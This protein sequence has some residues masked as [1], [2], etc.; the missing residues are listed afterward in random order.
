MQCEYEPGGS[1]TRRL[2]AAQR[3]GVYP[4][5]V[6]TDGRRSAAVATL[7][8]TPGIQPGDPLAWCEARLEIP[9]V[10]CIVLEAAGAATA[11]GGAWM[12]RFPRP[13]IFAFADAVPAGLAAL[14][15]GADIRVCGPRSAIAFPADP[16]PWL[17]IRGERLLVEG[18][19][20]PWGQVVDAEALLGLGLA[21]RI[22]AN[23]TTEA[24]RLAGVIAARGPIATELGKEAVWRGI[25]MPLEQALRLET[26]LTLLLQTTKDRAEGVRAFLEKRTPR[27]TGE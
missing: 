20:P 24:H 14:A 9:A 13:V 8:L 15:L 6:P 11:D 3:F 17:R 25:E 4:W 10:R 19:R 12:V 26:D 1:K 16:A 23:P 27:F 18:V 7:R 22:A 21:S 5:S 2:V